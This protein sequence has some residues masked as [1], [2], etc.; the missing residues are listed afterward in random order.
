MLPR[1]FLTLPGASLFLAL[2]ISAVSSSAQ[3]TFATHTYSG[4]NLWSQNEG[5][6]GHV[7][8]D[9]NDDGREDFISENDGSFNS[10]CTGSFAVTLSR[11]DGSYAAPVCYT[12]PSGVA[13]YFAVGDFQGGGY[14]D[15]AVTN[16]QGD[17]YIYQNEG[18]GTLSLLQSYQLEG[19]ASGIVAADV[20]HDGWPDL[21][22]DVAN[23]SSDTQALYV[24]LGEGGGAFETAGAVPTTT[25]SMG[26]EPAGALAVG[27]FD[28]DSHAD[29][30]VL[31]VSQVV[32]QILYGDGTG[33]FTPTS[34]FGPHQR[35]DP[36]DPNS[37]GT[38]SLIGVLP[39]ATGFSNTLDLEY[40]HSDRVLTSQHITLKSCAVGGNPVLADFD[41]DGNNDIVVAE[42]SDC[43]G[44]GPY[45]LNFMKNT[46]DGSLTPTFAPE[47]VIYSTSD[48]IW[49]EYV[50]RAS[51]S[52]KPD[53]T[54]FQSELVDGNQ[55]VNP[56]QLVLVNTTTGGFPAC[57]PSDGFAT[58]IDVCSPTAVT[59]ATSPVTFS[60][61]GSN[62]TPARDM[63]I[64]VDG[65]KVNENLH[66]NYSYYSFA[67][68]TVPLSSG[69]HTVT[70]ISV[71]WDYSLKEMTFPLTVG[72]DSCP[73]P[74]ED[75]MNICSPIQDSTT[76]SP[77]LAYASGNSVGY[78]YIVRMEVWVDGVKQFSSF[79]SNTLKTYLKLSPGWHRFDYYVVSSED[80]KWEETVYTNTQ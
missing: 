78:G 58:G 48:Y 59:G 38:E 71:G 49:G 25:F 62:Q 13:L 43:K 66:H 68:A 24:L 29:I 61:G 64:W 35:Y 3:V 7:R 76:T 5:R 57:T 33:H 69:T 46:G 51:H 52:S 22:Y 67:N 28:G 72:S 11:G 30:L 1:L 27:D 73:P 55:I 14:M 70:A 23:P 40:G 20:N 2:T 36:A 4:N 18:T 56:E 65:A 54:V 53:L 41:G 42:D 16:D 37:D 21:V 32:N 45:T 39:S 50:M 19:E 12:I 6:N 9:L 10:G 31:G 17:L 34:S 60:F 79:G 44:D 15:V 77:V 75:G 63:E 47:Q 8:A 26:G 80:L 74:S